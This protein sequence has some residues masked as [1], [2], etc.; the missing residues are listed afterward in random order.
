[1]EKHVITDGASRYTRISKIEARK[2]FNN[3]ES[4]YVIAH[5]MR[6]G[7]PFSMGMTIDGAANLKDFAES[8]PNGHPNI[9]GFNAFDRMLN[10]F[11]YYNCTHE[12]GYYAAFYLVSER[13][14]TTAK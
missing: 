4:L 9:P 3:G 1:M 13:K 11:S 12:T 10:N 8:Y 7:F 5:K 2:R 14:G 6:P